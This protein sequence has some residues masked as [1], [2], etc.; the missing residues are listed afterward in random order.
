MRVLPS[1]GAA[2]A[3]A[4]FLGTKMPII[5]LFNFADTFGKKER[6]IAANLVFAKKNFHPK[7]FLKNF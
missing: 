3:T 1:C 6:Q 5:E 7:N 4:V 2:Y